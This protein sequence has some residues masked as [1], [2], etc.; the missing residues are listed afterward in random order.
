MRQVIDLLM[1]YLIVMTRLGLRICP[2]Y[3]LVVILFNNIY[4]IK[5]TKDI[6]L[7]YI[8]FR[9]RK[10]YYHIN[11]S[12]ILILKTKLMAY[13][14]DDVNILGLLIHQHHYTSLLYFLLS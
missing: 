11:E 12:K 5:R 14:C 2:K 8:F 9:R 13:D 4:R 1:T 6:F 3:L 10:I 7:Y